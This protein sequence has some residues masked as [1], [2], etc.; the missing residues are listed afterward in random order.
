MEGSGEEDIDGIAAAEVVAAAAAAVADTAL[1]AV[2]AQGAEAINATTVA[3]AGLS[4]ATAALRQCARRCPA[5]VSDGWGTSPARVTE[6]GPPAILP[7]EHGRPLDGEWRDAF[8]FE[9]DE[10]G[11]TSLMRCRRG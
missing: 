7:P 10:H 5:M 3:Q 2:M 6:A 4:A 9:R 11:A 1:D 8:H